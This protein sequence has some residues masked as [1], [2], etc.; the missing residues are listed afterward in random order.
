[1]LTLSPWQRINDAS[2][3]VADVAVRRIWQV[4]RRGRT[5]DCSADA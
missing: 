5:S 3:D 4:L 1:L 2:A